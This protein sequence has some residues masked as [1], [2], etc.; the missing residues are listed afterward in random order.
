MGRVRDSVEAIGMQRGYQQIGVWS[1]ATRGGGR[2][3]K[4]NCPC[5]VQDEK[6]TALSKGIKFELQ[7]TQ[8]ITDA[9]S[10]GD[11]GGT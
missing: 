10:A 8:S 6:T 3:A 2:V 5:G 11:N 4:D 9:T 1:T 7:M